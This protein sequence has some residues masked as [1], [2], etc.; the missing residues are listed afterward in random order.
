MNVSRR[1]LITGLTAFIAAPAIVRASS[2][3]PVKEY[4]MIDF[5]NGVEPDYETYTIHKWLQTSYD[6]K[7]GIWTPLIETIEIKKAA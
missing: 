7:T 5:F 1:G 6:P 2:I 4:N 3:M